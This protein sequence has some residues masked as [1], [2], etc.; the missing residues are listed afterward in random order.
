MA[1][2]GC[3][4]MKRLAKTQ[5]EEIHRSR[6]SITEFEA[7]IRAL[8]AEPEPDHAQIWALRQAVQRLGQKIEEDERALFDLESV[9]TENCRP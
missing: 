7:K 4:M 8:E 9:I 3:A 1:E 6:Q 2:S 5:R